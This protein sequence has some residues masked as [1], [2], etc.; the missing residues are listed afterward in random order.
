MWTGCESARGIT[1]RATRGSPRNR[2][3][4]KRYF[5]NRPMKRQPK[6]MQ[7]K[8]QGKYYS[9]GTAN[10]YKHYATFSYLPPCKNVSFVAIAFLTLSL[11]SPTFKPVILSSFFRVGLPES[12][13]ARCHKAGMCPASREGAAAAW[14]PPRSGVRAAAAGAGDADRRGVLWDPKA[15]P[16][17]ALAGVLLFVFLHEICWVPLSV[18]T[19]PRPITA[20]SVHM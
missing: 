18:V 4:S 13:S 2:F 19:R 16:A 20:R 9:G 15:A 14:E 8:I 1:I 3:R 6:V 11:H 12:V 5:Q 10:G 17:P 7:L